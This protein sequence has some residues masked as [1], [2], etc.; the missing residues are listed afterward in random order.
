M[1]K[2]LLLKSLARLDDVIFNLPDLPSDKA[3]FFFFFGFFFFF[4]FFFFPPLSDGNLV[5]LCGQDV[6]LLAQRGPKKQKTGSKAV[7]ASGIGKMGMM[8]DE[9]S[10]VEE[11]K[12]K[13]KRMSIRSA[14]SPLMFC[15]FFSHCVRF[16]LSF[17]FF[18]LCWKK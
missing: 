2:D 13:K 10:A 6:I 17:F 11:A 9:A 5:L 3:S 14:P 1:E 7:L 8:S 18:F 15:L 12:K 16:V 4:W